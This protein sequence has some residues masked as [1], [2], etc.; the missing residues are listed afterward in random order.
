MLV[1]GVHGPVSRIGSESVRHFRATVAS[2][3]VSALVKC[4]EGVVFCEVLGEQWDGE[5]KLAA[6]GALDEAL[7]DE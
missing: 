3:G 7:L 1:Q 5:V 2:L 4:L 6:A